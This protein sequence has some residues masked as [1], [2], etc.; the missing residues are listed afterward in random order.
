L[1]FNFYLTAADATVMTRLFLILDTI[2]FTSCCKPQVFADSY[3]SPLSII[4]IDDIERII[5]YTPVGSRFSN[6]VL[7]TLFVPPGIYAKYKITNNYSFWLCR[8][9]FIRFF[10]IFFIIS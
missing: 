3:K 7:Q 10:F 9:L 6:S 4:F 8:A 2:Y 5:E 1:Y